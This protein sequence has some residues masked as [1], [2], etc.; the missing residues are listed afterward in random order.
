[1]SEYTCP[2]C[3]KGFSHEDV[4]RQ[5]SD[6]SADYIGSEEWLYLCECDEEIAFAIDWDPSFVLTNEKARGQDT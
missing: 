5:F 2:H 4:E 1:M 3:G 6:N